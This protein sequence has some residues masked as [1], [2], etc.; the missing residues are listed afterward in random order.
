[1]KTQ[2]IIFHRPNSG[3]IK[4]TGDVSLVDSTKDYYEQ[5]NNANRKVNPAFLEAVRDTGIGSPPVDFRSNLGGQGLVVDLY[6]DVSIPL[7]YNILDISEPD[8]RKTS[9]SKTIKVPGTKNNNRIF[10]HIYQ[11]TGDGWTKVGTSQVY[12]GFNPNLR[13]EI[14]LQSDGVQVMRGNLQLKTIKKDRNGNI[15]YEIALSGDLSSLFFD[16]G[17]AKLADLDFSEWDHEW[18]KNNI[19]NSW[20]GTLKKNGATYSNITTGSRKAI[21]TLFM[22]QTPTNAPT[23]RLCVETTSAHGYSVGDF[24][25]VEPGTRWSFNWM[26]TSTGVWVVAEV[27]SSTKF[28][29]NTPFPISLMSGWGYDKATESISLYNINPPY[30]TGDV[31]KVSHDGTGYV[32][33]LV[34]WGDEYDFNSFPVTSMAPSYYIKEIWDKIFKATNNRYQSNFLNSEFFKRLI[35]TQKKASYDLSPTQV[36]DR[37]FS[38]AS[39]WEITNVCIPTYGWFNTSATSSG[40]YAYNQGYQTSGAIFGTTVANKIPFFIDGGYYSTATGSIYFGDGIGA[41]GLGVGGNWNTTTYRWKVKQSGKYGL[42]CNLRFESWVDINGYEN[43]G[44]VNGTQSIPTPLNPQQGYDGWVYSTGNYRYWLGD[45]KLNVIMYMVRK[46]VYETNPTYTEIGRSTVVMPRDKVY[47]YTPADPYTTAQSSVNEGWASYFGRFQRTGWKDIPINGIFDGYFAK[48]EE[49][50]IEV[51][52]TME[53]Y[54]TYGTSPCCIMYVTNYTWDGDSGRYD[55]N[56]MEV[57]ANWYL[58]LK[59]LSYNNNQWSG[60]ISTLYNTPSPK[61]TENSIIYGREFLPKDMTCKDFLKNIIKTFNLYIEP[62]RQI[63]HL[64]YIEPRDDYY[65]TGSNGSS[66]YVDW[67]TKM[68]A[69]SVEIVPMGLLLAKSYVFQNKSETDY[70]NKRFKDERG[71]DYMLYRKEISNDFLKNEFKID[72]T[73]GST[74]MINNP[75]HSDVVMPAVHMRENNVVKP[76]SNSAPRMLIWVGI[77]PYA[78]IGGNGILPNPTS[79]NPGWELISS[80]DVIGQQAIAASASTVYPYAGTVDSPRDP[81]YDINWFNMEEGDFVY[82]DYAMWTNANLYNTYWKNFIDEVSDPASM[83]VK[84]DFNLSPKDI[85]DIDFRKIYVVDGV[86]YRIQ[87]IIDYDPVKPGLTK[88]ELLKLKHPTKFTRR[89]YYPWDTINAYADFTRPVTVYVNHFPPKK[90]KTLTG[91]YNNT[92][93]HNIGHGSIHVTGKGNYIGPSRNISVNGVEN[94]IG[95]GS[96]N[97]NISGNGVIVGAGLENIHVI[98]TSNISINESDVSYINGIRYKHGVPVSRCNIIDGGI[99]SAT[100]SNYLLRKNTNMNVVINV[101][102]ASED[103]IIESGS[104]THEDVIDGGMDMILP[105]LPELGLTTR[106]TPF[107]KTNYT[108]GADVSSYTYSIADIVRLNKNRLDA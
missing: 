85:F 64:Y 22:Q 104:A 37:S 2:L 28:A 86:Y 88:V 6:D 58:R 92:L 106:T 32:Y 17:D 9:W 34:S 19:I 25:K 84:A 43:S 5:S 7:T 46:K 15:E 98:G 70:W 20:S 29:L 31:Y 69:D 107:P 23:K 24:I 35:L 54:S 45:P 42:N 49:V 12:V 53:G 82:W 44:P 16:L 50:W 67:T 81:Y 26:A 60:S 108:S 52:Y 80:L 68:D 41:T 96:S 38:V 8:K 30:S 72:T 65:Y 27:I 102:D 18:S 40:S 103:T 48:D 93:P 91:D 59:G 39:S 66:D 11:I 47:N 56:Y 97:V 61:S 83:V 89:S 105:D 74:V 101:V 1:M 79:P 4:P 57:N 78:G 14:V 73:F 100:V 77:K 62:D 75:D 71:R 55:T 51:K 99:T 33:P 63:E 94:H 36:Q 87:K 21:K 10:S 3:G 90:V 95:N 13:T 76:V